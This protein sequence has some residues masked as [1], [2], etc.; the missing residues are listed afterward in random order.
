MDLPIGVR[1]IE[2]TWCGQV[3]PKSNY[4]FARTAQAKKLWARI[5]RFEEEVGELALE[6]WLKSRNSSGGML[7]LRP[8]VN[9]YVTPYSQRIDASNVSKPL[10][11]GLEGVCFYND[12][13]VGCHITEMQHDNKGGRIYVRVVWGR[14]D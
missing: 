4:R 8:P 1:S 13:D 10:L 11:D 7:K 9:V 14:R 5:R 12:K 6:A 2:F 3:P